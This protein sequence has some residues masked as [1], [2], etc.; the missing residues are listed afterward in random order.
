MGGRQLSSS[1]KTASS[2]IKVWGGG[3]KF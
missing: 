3:D 1:S 2:I